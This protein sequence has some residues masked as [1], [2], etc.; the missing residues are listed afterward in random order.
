MG[1]ILAELGKNLAD[2]WLTLLVLPGA[3]YLAVLAA[4]RTLGQEHALDLQRLAHQVSAWANSTALHSTTA[5]VAILVAVLLA[6]AAV[7]MAAQGIGSFIENLW[8]AP[9]WRTWPAPLRH[10]AEQ[11]LRARQASWDKAHASYLGE[12]D[13]AARALALSRIRGQAIVQPADLTGAREAMIRISPE[14]PARP[15][16]IG[17]RIEAVAVQLNR[18]YRLDLAT[19]WPSL[20]LAMPDSARSEVT[21]SRQALTS[22]TTLAGWGVLYLIPGALWWP[23]LVVAAATVTAAYRRARAAADTYARTLDASAHLYSSDL[24][25]QLGIEQAGPST[26]TPAGSSPASCKAGP[27]FWNHERG[28]SVG[29]TQNA[30]LR[31]RRSRPG[32]SP[33]RPGN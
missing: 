32:R 16:W 22:A 1:D 30:I 14:Y 17:D 28:R 33:R 6:A 5:L 29:R 11:R 9:G 13:A 20:W 12:R 19:V 31:R 2:R 26:R 25:R 10:I 27:S 23:G 18:D 21:A 3:L 4:A 7:G 15:T 8:L 24:A